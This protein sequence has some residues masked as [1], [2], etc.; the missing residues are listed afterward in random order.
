MGEALTCRENIYWMLFQS[1]VP[2]WVAVECLTP[3]KT[4]CAGAPWEPDTTVWDHLSRQ[5]SDSKHEW[6]TA[7]QIIL[8]THM[9]YKIRALFQ[10]AAVDQ[11]VASR[12]DCWDSPRATENGYSGKNCSFTAKGTVSKKKRKKQI[13][14][15]GIFVLVI[16]TKYLQFLLEQKIVNTKPYPANILMCL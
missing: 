7:S 14:Q 3:V 2:F 5:N 15:M 12:K 1:S 13:H 4:W 11:G 16:E 6:S 9:K 8:G 10:F